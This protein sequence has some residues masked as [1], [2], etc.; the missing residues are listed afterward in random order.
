MVG[1]EI[2]AKVVDPAVI[3]ANWPTTETEFNALPDLADFLDEGSGDNH[4]LYVCIWDTNTADL[5]VSVTAN[6]PSGASMDCC[7]ERTAVGPSGE[8]T[9]LIP[10]GYLTAFDGT[11][12]LSLQVNDDPL[13]MVTKQFAV[14]DPQFCRILRL[15]FE[16]SGGK[17][18]SNTISEI[19]VKLGDSL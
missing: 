9:E 7:L 19:F 3:A 5:Y 15:E 2:I 8:M 4:V 1:G 14:A 10:V 18:G 12:K 11:E 17:V 13:F 6:I 16:H